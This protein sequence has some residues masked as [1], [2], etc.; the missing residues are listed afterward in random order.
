M[1]KEQAKN[2]LRS[3]GFSEEQINEV[4]KALEPTTKNNT[5][6][7]D[8]INE[9]A[10]FAIKA[11]GQRD[12][13]SQGM[14]N[15]IEYLRATLTD[16]KPK[17]FDSNDEY[18]EP[19]TKNDCAEQNGCITCSLD[20]GDDCCRK[21]YEESMQE[22]TPKNCES[23]RY[24]GSHHEVCNYCYKCSLWTEQEPTTKNNLG[25]D[26]ISKQAVLNKILKFS[27]T[28]GRSVSVTSLWTEVNE[29]PSVT[30]QEPKTGKWISTETKGVRYAFWCRYKCSL[31][32][33]LSDY[34]NFCP[35]CGAK[36]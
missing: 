32:G 18:E 23:C 28:D 30:P 13:Y 34:K 7:F 9:L 11:T 14:C 17:Y 15:G 1:T 16:T 26:A 24:Y 4:V 29:L 35:N 27:V 6:D 5:V 36:M 12:S 22:P 2:Y 31:C 33:E 10:D 3:S 20:D 8:K 19:T 21:L 25:V